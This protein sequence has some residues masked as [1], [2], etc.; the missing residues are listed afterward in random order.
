MTDVRTG[1]GYDAHRFGGQGPVVLAGVAIDHPTGVLGT[2]DGDVAAHAV[3][4]AL[5]GAVGAGDLGA[6]FP[7]SDPKW[8]GVD[9][10]DL[11][12]SCTERVTEA[13]YTVSSVDVTIIVESICV[14]PYRDLMRQ[15]LARA[16][17]ISVEKVSVKATTM[18]GL[19]WIGEDA[20][21]AAQAVATVYA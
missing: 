9:S 12:R 21:L 10:L 11:L 1:I 6:Y 20:G 17:G 19:G 8:S 5:L 16:M 13:G 18:D 14:A 4:D 15:R 3:C 7:S 2:S